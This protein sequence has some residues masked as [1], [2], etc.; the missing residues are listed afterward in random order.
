VRAGNNSN[1]EELINKRFKM[2]VTSALA[3]HYIN[4]RSRLA[5]L[6]NDNLELKDYYAKASIFMF[7]KKDETILPSYSDIKNTEVFKTIVAPLPH[8]K[9]KKCN[10]T[11]KTYFCENKRDFENNIYKMSPADISILRD[12]YKKLKSDVNGFKNKI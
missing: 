2:L 3:V 8:M 4:S 6:S 10:D 11:D 7:G 12:K 9:Y 5:I 1:K